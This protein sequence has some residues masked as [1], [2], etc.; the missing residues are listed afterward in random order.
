MRKLQLLLVIALLALGTPAG[1][2]KMPVTLLVNA[3]IGTS[4]THDEDGQTDVID[5]FPGADVPFGMV[6]WSPDTPS[7]NP[8]GGYEY[9]DHEITGFSL[10]HLSGP[11]C[12]VFGDFGILPTLGAV[13]QPWSAKQPFL[14]TSEVASPGSYAVTLGDP[15]IRAELTVTPRTGLGRFTFPQSGQANV[16]FKVS[17]DQAG[18]RNAGFR[19]VGPDEVA[20]YA[21]TG[22]F[23]GMPDRYSAYF[24]A[25]FERPFASFGTWKANATAPGARSVEGAGSGGWVSFDAAQ[26]A[27]VRMKVGLSFVDEAGARANLRA[28]GTSWDLERVRNAAIVQWQRVLERIDVDGGTHAEQ[29]TFYTALYHALLHPNVFSDVTGSYR[30]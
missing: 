5:D 18:V 25:K 15:G 9:G 21:D 27:A 24:V 11:G 23:C 4:T 20:G 14:H 13:A 12:N 16:L 1:A 26:G 3:M 2:A 28:E 7:Q 30:G 10:T 19:V 29:R 22:G 8:G 17:S 6:Q